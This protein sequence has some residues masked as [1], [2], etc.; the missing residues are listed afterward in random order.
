M[1]LDLIRVRSRAAPSKS[2]PRREKAAS[3]SP[4]SLEPP[5]KLVRTKLV[6]TK[7]VR[8]ETGRTEK[9]GEHR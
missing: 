1:T 7:L 2:I 4:G 5:P 9:I 3:L 8:M 6:R